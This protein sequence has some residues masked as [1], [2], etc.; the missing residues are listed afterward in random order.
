MRAESSQGH[1]ATGQAACIAFSSAAPTPPPPRQSLQEPTTRTPPG[2]PSQLL[3]AILPYG[4][5]PWA[6]FR[7]S[8][9]LMGWTVSPKIAALKSWPRVWRRVFTEVIKLKGS[10]WGG[11]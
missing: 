4:S 6:Y 5:D 3:A 7:N 9:V 10:H 2:L 1:A 11:P 8:L